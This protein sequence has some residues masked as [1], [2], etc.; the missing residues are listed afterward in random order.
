MLQGVN[1]Q[2]YQCL[3]WF[4]MS[5]LMNFIGWLKCLYIFSIILRYSSSC[6][7]IKW[8]H[9]EFTGMQNMSWFLSPFNLVTVSMTVE[10][11]HIQTWSLNSNCHYI[12]R[13]WFLDEL[14]RSNKG[15][16]EE[17]VIVESHTLRHN[18]ILLIKC[19]KMYLILMLTI[20][21]SFSDI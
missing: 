15:L 14:M 16:S 5:T 19:M 13:E 4:S 10:Q 7:L 21:V 11:C 20:I 3:E 2:V 8:C 12:V 6:N 18:L 1:M 17:I 9:I